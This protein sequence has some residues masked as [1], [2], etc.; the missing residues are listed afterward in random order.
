MREDRPK[1]RKVFPHTPDVK[2]TFGEKKPRQKD[3]KTV[4]YELVRVNQFFKTRFYHPVKEEYFS[5]S[6]WLRSVPGQIQDP[7]GL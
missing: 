7:G 1:V 5:R 2:V 3:S 4:V 6:S